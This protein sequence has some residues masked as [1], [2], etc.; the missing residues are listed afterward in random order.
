MPSAS[1]HPSPARA[2]ASALTTG[3]LCAAAGVTRGA[4]RIYEREGLLGVPRRSG[5]GYRQFADDAV[6]RLQAI[7]LLREVGFSLREI[8]MLLAEQRSGDLDAAQMQ[9]LAREQLDVIDARVARLR[10]VRHYMAAVAAG[11]VDLIDDPECRFLVDFL[12]AGNAPE[13]GQRAEPHQ[14]H[15]SH[16][17]HD[18]LQ[19][20]P[21]RP[22]RADAEVL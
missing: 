1:R 19:P 15:S 2:P 7:R 22:S 6:A 21:A 16:V 17:S 5:A 18:S 12:A 13:P 4:L 3:A 9:A 20:H 10:Q 8:G 11:D 14:T